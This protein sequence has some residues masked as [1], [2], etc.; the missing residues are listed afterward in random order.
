[1][2]VC[3]FIVF[4]L[5]LKVFLIIVY[6]YYMFD[7]A[8]ATHMCH[9]AHTEGMGW[10]YG[11]SS[12]SP[13]CL[14]SWNGSQALSLPD[15]CFSL[16]LSHQ[17]KLLLI[18]FWDNFMYLWLAL[19]LLCDDEYD[20]VILLHLLPNARIISLHHHAWFSGF[21]LETCTYCADMY[22]RLIWSTCSLSWLLHA[23]IRGVC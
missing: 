21:L 18:F 8:G 5:K 4:T 6:N 2:C 19:N 17:S 16:Q 15:K 20:P 1:M 11:V 14:C 3:V 9:G 12:S 22:P 10:L 13:F 23:R 7:G